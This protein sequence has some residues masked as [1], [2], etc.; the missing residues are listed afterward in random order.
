L[1]ET[2]GGPWPELNVSALSEDEGELSWTERLTFF[3]LG[4]AAG[5]FLQ[6]AC[7]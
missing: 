3:L 2:Y 7:A 1:A 5:K 4:D 6:G